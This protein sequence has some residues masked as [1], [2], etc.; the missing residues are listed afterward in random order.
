[1]NNYNPLFNTLNLTRNFSP[2]PLAGSS[3][4]NTI[5]NTTRNGLFSKIGTS[6]MSLSSILNGAQKTIGTVNQVVPLYNQ[7]KPL[8]QNSKVLLNV[9][10]AVKGNNQSRKFLSPKRRQSI[11]EQASKVEEKQEQQIIIKEK[12]NPNTPSK[13]FFIN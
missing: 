1:M 11:Y 8:F 13:P 12:E 4:T 9:A 6:K 2:F 10:K 5:A 3:V 7:V